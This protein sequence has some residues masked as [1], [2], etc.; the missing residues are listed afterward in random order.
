MDNPEKNAK[1]VASPFG[2]TALRRAV[3]RDENPALR[4]GGPF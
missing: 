1:N 3:D 4:E 2:L